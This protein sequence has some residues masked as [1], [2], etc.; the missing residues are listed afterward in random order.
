MRG[1]FFLS[2]ICVP[3]RRCYSIVSLL[4]KLSV[5]RPAGNNAKSERF[6]YGKLFSTTDSRW[7]C[8]ARSDWTVIRRRSKVPVPMGDHG[9]INHHDM[10]DRWKVSLSAD[11]EK[12][13]HRS[14][15]E[16][17]AGP[18]SRSA[19]LKIIEIDHRVSKY[20]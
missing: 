11:L 7:Y 2:N 15:G 13:L 1:D 17:I 12:D 18:E 20:R 19:F 6:H 8:F 4:D 10:T 14:G 16:T 3:L 9:T 5:R